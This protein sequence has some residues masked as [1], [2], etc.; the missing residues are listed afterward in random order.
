MR[1]KLEVFDL[2]DLVLILKIEDVEFVKE[3]E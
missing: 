3:N 2:E 1:L